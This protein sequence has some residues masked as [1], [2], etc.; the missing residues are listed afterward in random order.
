MIKKPTRISTSNNKELQKILKETE[1]E[2]Q[3]NKD[4]IKYNLRV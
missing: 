2:I 3:K 4:I 1:K